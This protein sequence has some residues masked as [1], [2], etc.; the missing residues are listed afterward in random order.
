MNPFASCMHGTLHF[1][2]ASAVMSVMLTMISLVLVKDAAIEKEEREADS[3][4]S[5]RYHIINT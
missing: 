4:A 3:N 2:F 5:R 1:C